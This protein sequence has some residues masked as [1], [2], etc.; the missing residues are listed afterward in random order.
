MITPEPLEALREAFQ[1]DDGFLL[2]LRST[3]RWN[4]ASFARLVAAMQ[5]Y[6]E[7]T[8]H[9]AHLE[10]WIAEGF[11]IHDSLARDLSSSIA[12]GELNQAYLDA[13]C[14][15]LNALASWFFIGES[16]HLGDMPPFDA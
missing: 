5:R 10:R 14:Q 9:G 13:A 1:S 16:V 6:L 11:W 8:R 7:T 3:G 15:R 2:E 4:K 12:R